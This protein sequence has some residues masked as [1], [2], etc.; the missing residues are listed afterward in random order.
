MIEEQII[1]AVE[2]AVDQLP[3]RYVEDVETPPKEAKPIFVGIEITCPYC[4]KTIKLS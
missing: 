4:N 3:I 2:E 1:K